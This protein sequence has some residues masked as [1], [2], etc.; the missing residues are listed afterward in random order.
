MRSKKHYE[1]LLDK[2]P[3]ASIGFTLAADMVYAAVNGKCDA[4][5]HIEQSWRDI[6][7]SLKSKY[8]ENLSVDEVRSEMI[9]RPAAAAL[10]SKSEKKAASSR[11]NG[12]KGG[13][14]LEPT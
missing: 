1:E 4:S 11:E 10:G 3:N 9:K 6:A 5:D 12:K 7:R 2:N 8:G 14:G 13:G